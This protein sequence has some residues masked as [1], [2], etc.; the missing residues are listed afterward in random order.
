MADSKG[1]VGFEKSMNLIEFPNFRNFIIYKN[2]LCLHSQSSEM[3]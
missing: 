3:I 2:I 1:Y